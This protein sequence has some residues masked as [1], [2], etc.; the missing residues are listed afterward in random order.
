VPAGARRVGVVCAVVPDVDDDPAAP[1]DAA[2]ATG[3]ELPLEEG[4]S[5][6]DV[7]VAPPPL[8]L[9]GVLPPAG[10]SEDS[11]TGVVDEVELDTLTL[12]VEALTPGV[13]TLTTGVVTVTL[14]TVTV[15]LGTV[16]DVSPR[17]GR[18]GSVTVGSVT[19]GSV[20]LGSDRSIRDLPAPDEEPVS[21]DSNPAA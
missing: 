20:T 13:V 11:L 15:T 10:D 21:D 5:L 1:V 6:D 14:G 3:S 7:V 2:C 8:G 19:V 18:L 9:L 17:T 16:T 4:V 12:G